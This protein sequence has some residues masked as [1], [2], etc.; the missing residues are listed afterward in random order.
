[1]FNEHI[2]YR[3]ANGGSLSGEQMAVHGCSRN[4]KLNMTK[5]GNGRMKVLILQNCRTEGIGLYLT[6]AVN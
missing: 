3:T 4:S 1:M 6:G 5:K 2:A